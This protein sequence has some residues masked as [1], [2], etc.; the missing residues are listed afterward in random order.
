MDSPVSPRMRMV[1]QVLEAAKDAGDEGWAITHP[2]FPGRVVPNRVAI[3]SLSRSPS[4]TNAALRARFT[5]ASS[6]PSGDLTRLSPEPA[7]RP[8][9]LV[10]TLQISLLFPLSARARRYPQPCCTRVSASRSAG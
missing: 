1:W 10:R 2:Y 6:V 7:C 5:S 9:G 8:R 4:R 3:A